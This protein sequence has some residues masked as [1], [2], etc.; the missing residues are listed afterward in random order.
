M[1][2][3]FDV[4]VFN[5]AGR[6]HHAVTTYDPPLVFD[7]TGEGPAVQAVADFLVRAVL[8]PS[9]RTKLS[10]A[11]TCFILCLWHHGRV[12]WPDTFSRARAFLYS[13]ANFIAR[14]PIQR[15]IHR[16]WSKGYLFFGPHVVLQHALSQLELDGRGFVL[17]SAAYMFFKSTKTPRTPYHLCYYVDD[18]RVEPSRFHLCTRQRA[19]CAAPDFSEYFCVLQ[20]QIKRT[21]Q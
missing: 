1:E 21:E 15:K 17:I 8:S 12:K 6:L 13:L 16:L 18:E 7:H 4:K 2:Q 11:E 14:I 9:V 10:S 3:D 5:A 19:L 20:E